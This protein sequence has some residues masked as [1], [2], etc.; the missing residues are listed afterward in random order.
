MIYYVIEYSN[1]NQSSASAVKVDVTPFNEI[2]KSGFIVYNT[3]LIKCEKLDSIP[4]T[5]SMHNFKKQ[6]LK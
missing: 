5:V 3:Y 1:L 4:Y 6:F 2:L